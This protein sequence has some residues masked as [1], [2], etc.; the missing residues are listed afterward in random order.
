MY[1]LYGVNNEYSLNK[2]PYNNFIVQVFN[3]KVNGQGIKGCKCF[4]PIIKF[5]HLCFLYT[6]MIKFVFWKQNKLGRTWLFRRLV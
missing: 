3:F 2:K 4:G 6:E 5:P 1:I